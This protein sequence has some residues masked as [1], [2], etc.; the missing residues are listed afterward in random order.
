MIIHRILEAIS[1]NIKDNDKKN[2]ILQSIKELLKKKCNTNDVFFDIFKFVGNDIK[3]LYSSIGPYLT[4]AFSDNICCSLIWKVDKYI[5]KDGKPILVP[6]RCSKNRIDNTSLYCRSHNNPK[7]IA[8]CKLCSKSLE[9]SIF[10]E[11]NWEHFGN[12]FQF[13][14]NPCFDE[15]NIENCYRQNYSKTVDELKCISYADFFIEQNKNK[16]IINKHNDEQ[17]NEIPNVHFKSMQKLEKDIILPKK[18]TKNKIE[19]FNQLKLPIDKNMYTFI[20]LDDDL[21]SILWC[22]LLNYIFNKNLKV[23]KS[24]STITIFDKENSSLYTNDK[25]IYN[26]N[27]KIE[28]I[29]LNKDIA[30]FKDDIKNYVNSLDISK[31][32]PKLIKVFIKEVLQ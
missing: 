8:F 26:S 18:K 32:D 12:I 10:H 20:N 13:H 16:W 5:D 19:E 4:I 25:F 11:K 14:L 31:I 7:S 3:K 29:L 30:V 1:K 2:E 9:Q 15:R 22:L 27:F 17:N 28:G 21:R 23:E 6:C 24:I